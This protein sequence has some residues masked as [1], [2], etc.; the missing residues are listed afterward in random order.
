MHHRSRVF[1]EKPGDSAGGGSVA[2]PE[3]KPQTAETPAANAADASAATPAASAPAADV[4]PA[5][6]VELPKKD[7]RD[8]RIAKLTHDLNEERRQRAAAT[9]PPP[10]QKPGESDAEFQRR[11]DAAAD[12]KS[13]QKDWDRQCN[14]VADAGRAEF[15]DFDD[16]LKAIASTV[17]GQDP[18]EFQAYNDVIA[19]AIE[20]GQ[21]HK[22]IYALG[23]DPGEY[24]KLM[25]M[26]PVKRAMELGRMVSKLVGD[27]EPGNLPKPI[28]P[29]SPSGEHYEGIK[30]DDPQRGMKLP[31]SEWFKQREEQARA[32]GIQ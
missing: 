17:N 23:A 1:Y 31:K 11:V 28:S 18:T 15:K 3:P 13:A 12:L 2:Q 6:V 10:A 9:T 32:K 22:I 16:R 19:A 30:P 14:S 21:A 27:K 26:S 8:D 25:K 20:T 29:I 24:Q 4:K 5:A 7:W